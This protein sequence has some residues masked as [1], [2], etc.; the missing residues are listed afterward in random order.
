[1]NTLTLPCDYCGKEGTVQ[2]HARHGKLVVDRVLCEQC[3]ERSIYREDYKRV[4]EVLV[5][6]HSPKRKEVR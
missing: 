1:M 4:W 6:I 5:V 3:L 2:V